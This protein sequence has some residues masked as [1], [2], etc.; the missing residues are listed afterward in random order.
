MYFEEIHPKALHQFDLMNDESYVDQE[1][2][3]VYSENYLDDDTII[4]RIESL[5]QL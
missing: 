5:K 3:V 4:Y 1:F 2:K